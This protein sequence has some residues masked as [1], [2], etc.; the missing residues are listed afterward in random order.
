[1][2]PPAYTPFPQMKTPILVNFLSYS[3][4]F[5]KEKAQHLIQIGCI[6]SSGPGAKGNANAL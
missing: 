1:M 4:I 6:M 5:K 2:D 3:Y